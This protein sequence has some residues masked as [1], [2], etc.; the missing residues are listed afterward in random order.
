MKL[1]NNQILRLSFVIG[2]LA[3]EKMEGKFK[4]KFYKFS[5]QVE[6]EAK[7]IIKTLDTTESGYIENTESNIEILN[8]EQEVDLLTFTEEELATLP[9][10]LADIEAFEPLIKEDING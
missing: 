3:E 7:P 4:F 10:S 6:A 2:T 8:V 1:S 5:K 9:L